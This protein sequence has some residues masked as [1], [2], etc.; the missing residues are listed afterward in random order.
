MLYSLMQAHPL[1]CSDGDHTWGL[2]HV[3]VHSTSKLHG[4]PL[5]FPCQNSFL[6]CFILD[7]FPEQWNGRGRYFPLL[8]DQTCT[9]AQAHFSA[10]P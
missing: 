2:W 6:L 8:R 9:H 4:G 5:Q 7:S 10:T 1:T 3:S